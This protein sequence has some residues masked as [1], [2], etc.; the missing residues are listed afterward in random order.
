MFFVSFPFIYL[1]FLTF[2]HFWII[3]ILRCQALSNSELQSLCYDVTPVRLQQFLP[4]QRAQTFTA[5]KSTILNSSFSIRF[6]CFIV[7]ICSPPLILPVGEPPTPNSGCPCD[8]PSRQPSQGVSDFGF[9]LLCSS[10]PASRY[11]SS[12]SKSGTSSQATKGL[13]FVFFF[14]CPFRKSW[15]CSFKPNISEGVYWGLWDQLEA[16]PQS[17]FLSTKAFRVSATFKNQ[18]SSSRRSILARR[19]F[20][21]FLT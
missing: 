5:V 7:C 14:S 1:F 16:I 8:D 18:A 3:I 17:H 21:F 11:V 2:F 13:I 4:T 12:G 10:D 19:E 20:S 9:P 6:H 15:T